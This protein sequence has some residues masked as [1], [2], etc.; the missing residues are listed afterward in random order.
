ML[1]VYRIIL[2]L[3][4]LELFSGDVEG[5]RQVV[6]AVQRDALNIPWEDKNSRPRVD[7]PPG[8]LRYALRYIQ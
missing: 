3:P 5:D 4:S 1:D 7:K 6:I 2:H 8:R